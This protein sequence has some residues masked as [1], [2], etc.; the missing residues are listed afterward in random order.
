MADLTRAGVRLFRFGPFELDVRSGELRKH[1]VRLQLREQPVRILLLLLAHPGELVLRNEIRDKLWPNETVVEFDPAINNAIRRLRDAFGESAE[2]PRYIETVARR[3]Y[4]FLGE[5]EAVETPTSEPSA[6]PPLEIDADD[7][8]GKTVSH[9]LVLDKLGRGGMGIVFRAK[10]LKLK[11]NVALKFLPGEYSKDAQ[12]LERFQQEARAAAALNHPNICTIYEIGEHHSRPFIAMELLEG[13]TLKDILAEGPLELRELLGLAAQI[14]G[15][16]E[17][18]HR[19]GVV[20]RDIKPANLFVTRQ[21]QAKI[22][23]FG[24][25]KLV[26]GHSLNTVHQKAAEEAAAAA[27]PRQTV[28]SSPAGTAAYMS[29]EQV[30][31]EDVDARS[32]IF[33]LGVVLYEMAGGRRP[34]GG[35][36]SA[37]T[38]DAILRD[39]PPALPSSVPEALD[40][41]V[42]RCLEKAPD[43]RFQSAADLASALVSLLAGAPTNPEGVSSRRPPPNNLSVQ[44]A[45]LVGR[46]REVDQ[47][48]DLLRRD[49]T[50][51][52]T[53]TG[54]GGTGKTTLAEAVARQLR[55]EF[56]DGV[57]FIELAAIKQADLVASTIAQPLGVKE[58][59]GKP[60]LEALKDYSRGRNMLLVL[61]NFEH[62][63]TAAPILAELL[64]AAPR[65]KMLV[66][67][68]ALLHL[69][70]ER[71]YLVPPL[72]TPETSEQFSPKDLMGYEAVR[73][74]VERARGVKANFA[75]TEENTRSV[76]EICVRVDGLPLA[77]EL[78][79]ARVKVLSPQ[80]I[81]SRLDRRLKLLTGGALDLPTRQ[82]TV[83]GA[84][85]WS[86]ELLPDGEKQLFRRLAVFAG[87]FTLE[88]VE[89]VVFGQPSTVAK[90]VTAEP[91]IEALEGITSLVDK[92]LLVPKPETHGE[93]RFRML[94]VVREYA[95][96]RL[97]ASG[98]AEQMRRRHAAYFLGIAEEAEPHLHGPRPAEW[99]LRLEEEH[100]NIRAALRWS[101]CHDAGMAARLGAAIRYFWVFHGHLA[102]GLAVSQEILMLCDRAPTT[103]RWKLLSM[104][105]NLARYQGDYET[106]RRLYEQGLCDGRTVHDLP[107][108]SLFCRGLGGLA[109][110][111]GDYATARG[112]AAEALCVARQSSDRFGIARSLN[113]IGDLARTQG[114]DAAAR[115][116]YEESIAI[117]RELGNNYATANILTNLAAAEFGEGNYTGAHAHF[118][119][120]LAMLR[121]SNGE[122]VGD[123]ISVSY[124]L[125]GLA[126][127]ASLRGEAELAAIIAGT[128][129]HLR[130]SINYNIEPAERRFRDAYM[131]SLRTMLSEGDFSGAYARGRKLK[132]DDCV[133]LALGE[134]TS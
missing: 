63:P 80:A 40:R 32:D 42:R 73:L 70:L 59:G 72:A 95:L 132:L 6:S 96:Y 125:D 101:L 58:A 8:E 128:A 86:Y 126:A 23:D 79:A 28:P 68:R 75:L 60:S 20:H 98:E 66:T 67:S 38:M 110:E 118:T 56:C 112:F 82:Q 123:K 22:L 12:P 16:L 51:L 83:S 9:Y 116:L 129:E 54:V 47:V 91:V 90:H 133:A 21:K 103:M 131:A 35:G 2:K 4:R 107:Q 102:E 48:C 71:E 134:K 11:R 93:V 52:L 111:Q 45:S 39:N 76:A 74:F 1:G 10:D 37:E 84:M 113:M 121:E 34:F 92:S 17:A 57:F 30:R 87:G 36:S 18:A 108:V 81:L 114:E 105:G 99:L 115:P 109:L 14:A 122:I 127:L 117:C 100:G 97:E 15:G 41:V 69:R 3:G 89:R 50:R 26:S 120:G 65:L 25:A 24:L 119:E 124:L 88:A 61:D 64:A 106:A 29:P 77:I 33:S 55:D 62:L 104:A 130:E 85:E 31:G 78:A 19:K 44:H 53:L 5:V 49:G 94:E 7:L 46:E 13:Q 27:A 43:G